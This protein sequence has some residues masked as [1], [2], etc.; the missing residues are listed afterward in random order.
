MLSKKKKGTD[1]LIRVKYVYEKEKH[2]ELFARSLKEV[3][4]LTNLL[5]PNEENP[6]SAVDQESMEFEL[7]L[8]KRNFREYSNLI[9]YRIVHYIEAFYGIKIM[10]FIAEYLKDDFSNLWL[11]NCCHI[12]SYDTNSL[13][14]PDYVLKKINL[15]DNEKKKK[16]CDDLE[17]IYSKAS[18]TKKKKIDKIT[19]MF[20]QN[21]EKKK[22]DLGIDL[23]A[24][25]PEDSFSDN[26]FKNLN[27]SNPYTLSQ[28]LQ[29]P[30][31]PSLKR[32]ILK[33]FPENLLKY[34]KETKDIEKLD[35]KLTNSQNLLKRPTSCKLKPSD[36][37]KT[38]NY[39]SINQ[40]HSTKFGVN[41]KNKN[42]KQEKFLSLC[43]NGFS[44]P[45]NINY[46]NFLGELINE[47]NLNDN[48]PIKI[49]NN[50]EIKKTKEK[51]ITYQLTSNF[52]KIKKDIE[53]NG[54]DLTKY[55]LK[56]L[57]YTLP[58]LLYHKK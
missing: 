43:H 39:T 38:T 23:N 3:C 17:Q 27:P 4:Y 13:K 50:F 53:P 58:Y 30:H 33:N 7:D 51:L 19:D 35:S 47:K 55:S 10:K 20:I 9:T 37:T 34:D 24:K 5:P 57:N 14:E 45:N 8:K 29:N 31:K 15:I 25:T 46:N 56:N 18:K 16:L 1:S 2:K 40:T 41:Y 36:T 12:K 54:I 52:F 49:K 44:K 21:Y 6:P 48:D 22:F 28:I 26:V 11:M 32:Y 42:K